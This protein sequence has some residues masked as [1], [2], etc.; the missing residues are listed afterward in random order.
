M[1]SDKCENKQT[2]KSQFASGEGLEQTQEVEAQ[3]VESGSEE[4]KESNAKKSPKGLKQAANESCNSAEGA[5]PNSCQK[6][7]GK[8]QELK[9]GYSPA[10][11]RFGQKQ[12][13]PSKRLTSADDSEEP[14]FHE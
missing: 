9:S 13:E 3:G 14:Q 6:S 1:K 10:E 7:N 11:G 5:D 8:E 12:G 4:C 2:Q